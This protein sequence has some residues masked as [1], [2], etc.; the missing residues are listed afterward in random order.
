MRK[1]R[2]H[3]N[4]SETGRN[5]ETIAQVNQ[6]AFAGISEDRCIRIEDKYGSHTALLQMLTLKI[7]IT[8]QRG[9]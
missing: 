7:G 4:S 1:V 9:I 5:L 3:R 2:I 6:C 8:E